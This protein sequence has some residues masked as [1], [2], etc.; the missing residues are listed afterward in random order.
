MDHGTWLPISFS[1]SFKW[2]MLLAASAKDKQSIRRAKKERVGYKAKDK[3][4]NEV[5]WNG[6]VMTLGA[7]GAR[8]YRK[9]SSKNEHLI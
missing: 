7:E 9:T 8:T 3:S 5:S 6:S 2:R 4:S 1:A